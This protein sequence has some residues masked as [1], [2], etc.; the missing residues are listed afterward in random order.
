MDES[1]VPTQE[2]LG[3]LTPELRLVRAIIAQAVQDLFGSPFVASG[4]DKTLIR[5]QALAFLTAPSGAHA[6]YR[7]ELCELAG[8]DGSTLRKNTIEMLEGRRS[9]DF[10]EGGKHNAETIAVARALWAAKE[11]LVAPTTRVPRP[12]VKPSEPEPNIRADILDTL[13]RMLKHGPATSRELSDAMG[14]AISARS[15]TAYLNQNPDFERDG[16]LWRLVLPQTAKSL[17][18]PVVEQSAV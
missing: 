4:E 7:D 8:L 5:R 10:F 13:R 2:R 3:A 11:P 14:N 6:K 12:P 17:P 9:T 15:V 18:D 1:L 16:D